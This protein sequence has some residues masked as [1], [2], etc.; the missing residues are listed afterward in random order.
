MTNGV[1]IEQ[2]FPTESSVGRIA[3][4]ALVCCAARIYAGLCPMLWSVSANDRKAIL[5]AISRAIG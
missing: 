4:T 5:H 1:S 3:D 2:G